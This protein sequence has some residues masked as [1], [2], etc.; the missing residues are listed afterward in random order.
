MV[1]GYGASCIRAAR[2]P[3][4]TL[5]RLKKNFDDSSVWIRGSGRDSVSMLKYARSNT[6]HVN[7]GHAKGLTSSIKDSIGKQSSFHCSEHR[8]RHHS[9]TMMIPLFRARILEGS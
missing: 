8:K 6:T 4:Y 3:D 9:Q 7:I 1:S 2:Q 5:N